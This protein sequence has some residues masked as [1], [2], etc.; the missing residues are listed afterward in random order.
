MKKQLRI[1]N[2]PI[3][4]I[5]DIHGEFDKLAYKIINDARLKNCYLVVLGD[6]GFGFD[7]IEDERKHLEKLEYVCARCHVMLGFIR[8][9]HDNPVYWFSND[10][11]NRLGI[12]KLRHIQFL[13]DNTFIATNLTENAHYEYYYVLGGALSVDRYWRKPNESWWKGETINFDEGAFNK[14]CN[15]LKI[16]KDGIRAILSHTGIKP[17]ACEYTP[18]FIIELYDKDKTLREDINNES[19]EIKRILSIIKPQAIYYGHWHVSE[20]GCFYRNGNYD[21][22][23]EYTALNIFEIKKLV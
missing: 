4:L 5:G 9:N 3:Y 13:Q 17:H 7:I 18:R 2:K 16:K 20:S 23:L 15:S 6:C 14:L 10:I 8:G 22:M 12:K 21:D 11:Q 19:L 1:W